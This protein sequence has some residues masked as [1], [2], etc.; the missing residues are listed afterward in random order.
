MARAAERLIA[1]AVAALLLAAL[2]SPAAAR[3]AYVADYDSETV[4]VIDISANRLAAPPLEAA[5]GSGPYSLAVTPDG[6]TA[7]V[8]NYNTGR[9][10][11]L[12]TAT[13]L[14]IGAP[15]PIAPESYGFAITPDGSRAYVANSIDDTVEALDLNA[16]ARIGA[17]IPVGENPGAVAITPDGTRAYVSNEGSPEGSGAI[18]VIDTATNQVVGP[19][20]AVGKFPYTSAITPDGRLLLVPVAEG[21]EVIDTV[22]NQLA[23]P[24]IPLGGEAEASAVVISPDGRRAYAATREPGTVS[25]I[26]VASRRV[27]AGPIP[28]PGFVEFLTLSPDGSRLLAEQY[29]PSLDTIIDTATN[30]AIGPSIEFGESEGQIAVVPDQ[31]P[32]AGFSK[33]GRA[34][35]G[36]PYPLN[37]SASTDPD[38]AVASWGWAFGDGRSATTTGPSVRHAFRK[39][40]KFK[41][42]LTVTDD[43]GCSVA[44][45]FT[46]QTAYC[47]GSPAATTTRTVKVAYP[48]VRVRCPKS[49]DP[50]CR[51][52][53]TAVG[54]GDG[55]PKA[56][57]ALARAR[58][59]PGK[60]ATVA[61]KPKKR[62]AR[63]L[64]VARRILVRQV[65]T[66][67]G[68]RTTKV[69]RLRVVR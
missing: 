37:G 14:F 41:V 67:D 57:S 9:V 32:A 20:I 4:G 56:Q 19:Q 61:L 53:L 59:R 68:E 12:D 6:R 43:E 16:R 52:E 2:P 21:I 31:S 13:N 8:V 11:S 28:L 22:T 42:T 33:G 3:L 54:G 49:A 63:R 60:K 45:V 55:K 39:P 65:A 34:R 44:L 58:V 46:G 29:E 36:V 69:S 38:G 10:A 66:I 27:V 51:Y 48:G 18:S 47:H 40:G 35:P 24:T 62:F 5:G 17:P 64:A 26:D 1:L 23:G 15:I 7:W 25:V 30:Q 50:S